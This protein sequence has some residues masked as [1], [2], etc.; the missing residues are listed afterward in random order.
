MKNKKQKLILYALAG[1]I[2]ALGVITLINFTIMGVKKAHAYII[3]PLGDYL[4][5]A[6]VAIAKTKEQEKVYVYNER[7]PEEIIRQEII[8][9]AEY[10]GN[11]VEFML[12][13]AKCESTFNNLAEN[14]KS[15]AEGVYQYLYSTWRETE[16]G[17]QYISRFDYKANIK[18]ANLDIANGEYFRWIECLTN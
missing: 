12:N 18:E 14:P 3:N 1:I 9:Q 4:V 7:V 11:N 13:L 8:E 10:Y 6:D 2:L 16:S 17:K 15:S 5:F